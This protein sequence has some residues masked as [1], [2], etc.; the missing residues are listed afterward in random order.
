MYKY[1]W[2]VPLIALVMVLAGCHGEG[3]PPAPT[4][5]VTI[6]APAAGANIPQGT[7]QDIA[8][9]V[10]ASAGVDR[11]VFKIDGVTKA[12]DTT[13]PYTYAWDTTGETIGSHSILVTAY[14]KSTPE[15]SATATRNVTVAISGYA[16]YV[17]SAQVASGGTVIVQVKMTDT[18][19]VAGF[20]MTIKYDANALTVVGGNAGVQLGESAA[21]ASPLLMANTATAGVITA[22]VAG[23]TNFDATKTEIL[24]IEFQAIGAAGA[25]VVD[26]D[27]T[28]AAPTEL[29]FSDNTGADLAPQPAAVDGTVT[30]Q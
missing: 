21:A 6:T 3:G 4:V 24:T 5:S 10:T 8:A 9:T 29:K 30:I 26:I 17:E 25:T 11:V 18:T 19:G 16:V 23:T 1:L 20:Q 22:A 27:D 12:T 13:A 14:D 15:K 28:A 2:V 7:T